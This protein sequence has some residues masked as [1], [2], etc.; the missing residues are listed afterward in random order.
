MAVLS[1]IAIIGN[2]DA[3]PY[4][5][6]LPSYRVIVA[7]DGG[8]KQAQQLGI[9]PTIN[10]GDGDS[11]P[12]GTS[13]FTKISEQT[14][15]DLHKGLQWV[16]NHCALPYDIDLFSVTSGERLDHTLNAIQL[17]QQVPNVRHIYTPAQC[18]Q[19]IREQEQLELELPLG[20]F[21]SLIP[22]SGQATVDLMGSEW[23][24]KN[25]ILD[26]QHSGISNVTT[27]SPLTIKV[28][29]GTVLCLHEQIWTKSSR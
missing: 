14:T 10:L 8:S 2:G 28:K 9:H 22:M 29:H 5:K 11:I 27:A 17:A 24:G 25:I 4:F 3:V 20:T 1:R 7:L 21:F 16:E 26:A 15:T 6:Q 18:L 12:A 19:L 23:S 13:A